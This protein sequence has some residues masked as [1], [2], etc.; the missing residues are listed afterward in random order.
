MLEPACLVS[1]RHDVPPQAATESSVEVSGVISFGPVLIGVGGWRHEKTARNKKKGR[2]DNPEMSSLSVRSVGAE[3]TVMAAVTEVYRPVTGG[4][5][6]VRRADV[7][8][9]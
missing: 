1:G 4:D 8:L 3:G 9:R 6:L 2:A 7:M 5:R